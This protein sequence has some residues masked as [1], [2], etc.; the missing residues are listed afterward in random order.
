MNGIISVAGVSKSFRGT[1]V[2][3][4]VDVEV[5]EGECLSVGGPNGSGKS[6]LLRLMCRMLTP[7]TGE[8]QIDPRY[9]A[10][11]NNFPQEFGVIIDRPGFQALRTGYENLRDLARIRG[12]VGRD[13]I[14]QTMQQVGLDPSL[15]QRVGQYSLGMKQKLAL[16]QAIM[17]RQ[18]VLLL[19]EP[20]NALDVASVDRV[21][22][23]LRSLLHQG[24][25]IVFCSHNPDDVDAL[26]TRRVAIVDGRVVARAR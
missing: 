22:E 3:S 14:L 9:Q 13:E 21:R 15:K 1:R 17:E 23:L 11:G 4:N 26:A 25:T 10:K 2:L 5:F 19:D 8:V 20:F 12:V 18:H 24:R 16:V 7:D 6:V